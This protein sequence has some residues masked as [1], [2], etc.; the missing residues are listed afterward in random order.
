MIPFLRFDYHV[1]KVV[2]ECFYH[3]KNLSKIKRYLTLEDTEKLIHAIVSS[4]FD[5]CNALLHGLKATTLV[6]LQ[7]V[8]NYAAR[9]ARNLPSNYRI[10][11]SVLQDLHWLSV[12]ERITFKILLLVHKF[13]VGIAPDYFNELLIVGDMQE[14]LLCHHFMNTVSGMR[15][16][17]FSASR[18][19]NR[20]PRKIR[21]ENNTQTFKRSIKTVLFSNVN[22]ITQADDL[23]TR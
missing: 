18:F 3:L 5:Y 11:D 14:R 4:K 17:S 20:L 1:N 15:S 7:K 6:K 22:N 13:F 2:S 16:F 9:I 21:F 19:W 8:Q 10:T 23:Y 12:K